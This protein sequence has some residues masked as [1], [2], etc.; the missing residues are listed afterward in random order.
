MA[1]VSLVWLGV[2]VVV[3]LG[4]APA[5]VVVCIPAGVVGR[6]PAGVP[7]IDV[8]GPDGCRANVRTDTTRNPPVKNTFRRIDELP[9]LFEQLEN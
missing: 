4:V 6:A 2:V 3:W 1:S 8:G 5:G 7:C 9:D